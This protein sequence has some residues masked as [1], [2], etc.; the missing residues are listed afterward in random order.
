MFF[1]EMC[2]LCESGEDC[3]SMDYLDSL[4]SPSRGQ[5]CQ[6]IPKAPRRNPYAPQGSNGQRSDLGQTLRFYQHWKFSEWKHRVTN[7][8]GL[9]GIVLNLFRFVNLTRK[10]SNS[11]LSDPSSPNTEY[12]PFYKCSWLLGNPEIIITAGCSL[13]G[14]RWTKTYCPRCWGVGLGFWIYY[15]Q[16]LQFFSYLCCSWRFGGQS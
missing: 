7:V 3:F 6:V 8:S 11:L 4:G 14:W 16:P 1:L 5:I 10:H 13:F 12:Y 9:C 2:S 15:L